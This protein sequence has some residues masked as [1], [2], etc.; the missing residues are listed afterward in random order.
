[1]PATSLTAAILTPRT[2]VSL[3]YEGVNDTNALVHASMKYPSVLLENIEALSGVRCSATG[4]VLTFNN[5]AEY[6]E[7][8]AIWPT[9]DFILFTNHLGDCDAENERG[10]YLVEDLAYDNSSL[11]ITATANKTELKDQLDDAYIDFNSIA[12]TTPTK[13][14][15][16]A[17][18]SADLSGATL[19]KTDPLTIVAN[20]AKLESTIKLNGHVHYNFL[21]FKLEEFYIDVDYSSLLNLNVSAKVHA[22]YSTDLYNYTP[23]SASVSAFTIP[24]VIDVGPMIEF[25]LGIE[26][27]ASGTVEASVDLQSQLTNSNVHLDFLDAGKTTASGWTPTN[28]VGT[29]VSAEVD[30]QINPYADLKLAMGVNLFSGLLDLSAGIEAKPTIVNAF[31]VDVD[32]TYQ[33]ST[34]VNFT[35]PTGT[36]CTNGAWF[37]STFHF[38][39]DAFV[40][41]FYTTTLYEVD[42]PIYESQCWNFVK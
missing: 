18:V 9:S 8:L 25:G 13:R 4:V 16:S 7:S 28:T 5:S 37:A 3:A 23:L 29:H 33:S 21:K 39:V 24:G 34:G 22:E 30:L 31:S 27:A 14:G 2:N 38:E 1:M 40:T 10:V 11:T 6:T 15:I 19:I 12:D 26:F 17:S 36:T 20:E 32:F 42:L 35:Q 41:Q